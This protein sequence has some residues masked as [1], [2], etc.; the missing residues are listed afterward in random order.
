MARK[1]LQSSVDLLMQAK[2]IGS[3]N[4]PVKGPVVELKKNGR[5]GKVGWE[6][7]NATIAWPRNQSD[8]QRNGKTPVNKNALFGYD[9]RFRS[10]VQD[11][12]Q[13]YSKEMASWRDQPYWASFLSNTTC[14]P[15]SSFFPTSGAIGANEGRIDTS[16]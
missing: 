11:F 9:E 16:T 13:V 2:Q 5:M 14:Y 12:W 15:S 4:K 6:A 1:I 3:N 10:M 8:Y 7:V